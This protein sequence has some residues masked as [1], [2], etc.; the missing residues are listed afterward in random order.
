VGFP[1]YSLRDAKLAADEP[2]KISGQRFP[3]V[4]SSLRELFMQ[5]NVVY[6]VVKNQADFVLLLDMFYWI[7]VHLM[8]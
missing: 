7:L 2:Q 8:H 1:L 5:R 6:T 4:Y 3:Y